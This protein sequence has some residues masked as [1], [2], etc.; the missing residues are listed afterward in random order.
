MVT[1]DSV[2]VAAA[3]AAEVGIPLSRVVAGATPASKCAKIKELRDGERKEPFPETSSCSAQLSDSS[4]PGRELNQPL[5]LPDADPRSDDLEMGLSRRQLGPAASGH[6]RKARVVA[7]VGDGINDSPA[8]IEADV[9]IAIGAGGSQF[10]SCWIS[11][12]E[13]GARIV[14][15]W[16]KAW[17]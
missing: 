2:R 3:L 1:G 10:R 7:M 6:H 13:R 11:G 4:P 15:S 9:G 17:F 12:Q 8:L 5:L 16:D 14:L